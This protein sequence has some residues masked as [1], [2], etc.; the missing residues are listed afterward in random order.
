M[1]GTIELAPDMLLESLERGG[2]VVDG[3]Q[4]LETNGR[5]ADAAD[6]HDV[7]VVIQLVDG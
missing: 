3:R 1:I 6:G 7:R 2:S 5:R 4:Q